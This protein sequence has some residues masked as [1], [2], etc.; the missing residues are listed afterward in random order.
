MAAL[1]FRLRSNVMQHQRIVIATDLH[2]LDSLYRE[3]AE[4]VELHHPDVVALAGDFLDA[5]GSRPKQLSNPECA[6]VLAGLPCREVVFTRGNHEDNNWCE[7]AQAWATTGKRLHALHGDAFV[8]GP[9]VVVGF[10]CYLGDERA[11]LGARVPLPIEPG[12]WLLRLRREYGPAMRTLWLMHEPPSSTVLTQRSGP[13]AGEPYWNGAIE[14]FLP[15]LTVSGHDHNTPI[16]A[17]RWHA[18]LGQTLVVNAGQTLSGPLHYTVLEA[19][20]RNETPCLPERLKITAY[21]WGESVLL[22]AEPG[23]AESG[24]GTRRRSANLPEA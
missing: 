11:Y 6:K 15:W 1:W 13:I 14:R 5:I 24:T 16:E 7:F 21:P 22:P 2:C 12:P 3:L 10:P 9:L 18:W 8:S 23:G 19:E 20:F 4:V 17:N